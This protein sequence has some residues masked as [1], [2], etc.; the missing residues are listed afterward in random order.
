M[1]ESDRIHRITLFEGRDVRLGVRRRGIGFKE[2]STPAG[3]N[4]KPKTPRR[5]QISITLS[6]VSRILSRVISRML[7]MEEGRS[8]TALEYL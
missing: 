2:S 7:R 6:V 1:A 4:P 5:A 3:G 8:L